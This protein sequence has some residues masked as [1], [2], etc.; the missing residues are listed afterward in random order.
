ME[1]VVLHLH[2]EYMGQVDSALCLSSWF[3]VNWTSTAYG[4]VFMWGVL[5]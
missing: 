3:M 1:Q 5:H 4:R 2:A